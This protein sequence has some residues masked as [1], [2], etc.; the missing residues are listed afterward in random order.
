MEIFSLYNRGNFDGITFT[1]S[2][3]TQQHFKDECDINSIMSK[4]EKTGLLVDP[5]QVRRGYPNFGDF[6]DLPDY[7]TSQNMLI[8]ANDMFMNLPSSIRKRFHNDPGE[9]LAFVSDEKNRDEAVKLGLVPKPEPV[10]P[11]STQPEIKPDEP[12]PNSPT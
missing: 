1:D 11:I 3:M 6:D 7:Q 5:L 4:Y 9:L 2:T 12:S 10:P 8:E